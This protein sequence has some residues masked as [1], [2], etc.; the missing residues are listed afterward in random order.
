MIMAAAPTTG[1]RFEINGIKIVYG[2]LTDAEYG[3]MLILAIERGV[4]A[5]NYS[6]K[7]QFLFDDL[8]HGGEPSDAKIADFCARSLAEANQILS[9]EF[10]AGGVVSPSTPRQKVDAWVGSLRFDSSTNQIVKK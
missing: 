6:W 5:N 8:M 10:P 4:G 7:S 1:L 3:E 2:T 9:T